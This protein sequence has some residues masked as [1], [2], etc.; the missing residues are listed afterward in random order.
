MSVQLVHPDGRK[1]SVENWAVDM[2][3]RQGFNIQ[4]SSPPTVPPS[5]NAAVTANQSAQDKRRAEVAGLTFSPIPE[6]AALQKRNQ[7]I[8]IQ[9]GK[10]DA[11]L[12]KKADDIR[13]GLNPNY[14]G[15][16]KGFTDGKYFL[17]GAGA[18]QPN[19]SAIGSLFDALFGLFGKTANTAAD[20][21]GEA[22]K[23]ANNG[24]VFLLLGGGLLLL[25]MKRR[26]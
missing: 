2:W 1:I 15:G 26:R 24:T 8:Y 5:N 12:S 6:V 16:E 10:W 17:P 11:G 23:P 21:A 9:T 18:D 20:T 19:V 25:M 22:T 3:R 4:S 14:P 7:D 13:M